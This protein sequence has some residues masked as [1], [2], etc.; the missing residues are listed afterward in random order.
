MDYYNPG[1][2]GCHCSGR[3]VGIVRCEKWQ[4]WVDEGFHFCKPLH[5]AYVI[6]LRFEEAR[7]TP[8]DGI[9]CLVKRVKFG[10]MIGK[11]V[12]IAG[13]FKSVCDRVPG[14]SFDVRLRI[15]G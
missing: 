7:R 15:L 12:R 11:T 13:R 6:V 8:A 5:P 3:A 10:V 14:S 9:I 2:S 4:A 1:D